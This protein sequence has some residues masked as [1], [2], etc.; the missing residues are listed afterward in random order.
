MAQSTN[1]AY[2]TA[3]QLGLYKINKN[4]M[5]ALKALAQ[6]F[7]TKEKEFADVI[8]MGRTQLQDAVP[9]TLGQTFGAY[10]SAIEN[11]MKRLDKAAQSLL[12]INMVEQL[13]VPV[14]LLSP[15]MQ[16]LVLKYIK[17]ITDGI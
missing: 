9:M 15:A 1:D 10:A 8:K 5:A 16:R 4:V 6:S 11:E 14:L 12:V 3:M 7:R 2:P 13:L 17:E